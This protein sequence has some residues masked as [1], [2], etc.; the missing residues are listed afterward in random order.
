MH[1]QDGSGLRRDGRLNL[2]RVEVEGAGIHVDK[3]RLDPVPQ[4]RMGGRNKRIRRGNHLARDSQCLQ[5][6]YQGN[7]GVGKNADVFDA[8]IRTQGIFKLVVKRAAV[9]QH[10]VGPD[11]LQIRHELFQWRKVGLG[12]IDGF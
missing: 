3:H 4:Q 9:G 12:H 7:R 11:L 5:S 6:S 8:Q 1:R 2:R 10:L